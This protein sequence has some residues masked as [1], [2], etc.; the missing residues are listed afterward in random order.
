[1]GRVASLGV[2][3][4]IALVGDWSN[5]PGKTPI[6]EWAGQDGL[7]AMFPGGPTRWT[8]SRCV[9]WGLLKWRG[10][11]VGVRVDSEVVVSDHGL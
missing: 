3:A 8:S 5:G 6:V 1:M 4:P 2:A 7:G 9:D 10:C 11:K